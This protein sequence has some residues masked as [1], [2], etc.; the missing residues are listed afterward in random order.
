MKTGVTR[1]GFMGQAA[2][3]AGALSALATAAAPNIAQAGVVQQARLQGKL[4]VVQ[5]LDFHP[6]HNALNK[7]VIEDWAATNIGAQNLDLSDLAGFLGSS[8]IYEK[9]QAQKQAGQPVDFLFHG[10]SARLLQVYDLVT[11]A[12]PLVN[13][14][15][16]KWGRVYSS[17]RAQHVIDNKWIGLPFY[18]R[19]GG[20]W[21]R[22]DKFAE[23]GLSL[24]TGFTER[25]DWIKD[26][27]WAVSKP[28]DN[29]YGW[30][31][32]VNRSGDGQSLVMDMIYAW[33]GAIAD[34]TGQ[35]VTLFSPETIDAIQWLTDIYM[36]PGFQDT[37][38]PPGVNS[39]NDISNNEAWL[40]GTL[41][42]TS[43]A[44]TLYAKS[45]FDQTV[46]PEGRLLADVTTF[47]QRPY[48]PAGIRLQ[49]SGGHYFYFMKGSRNFDV[50]A[51]LA[52]HML[53][54]EV[55]TQLWKISSGY[56]V[57][58]YENR[59]DNPIISENRISRS[60]RPVS[61]NEP[62]FQGVAY[63]GPL[64][65]A[66]DAV[67]SQTVVTDMMGEILAGKSVI[68]AVRDAHLRCVD[69]YQSFGYKGR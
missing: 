40:A 52:E 30:G 66:A 18:D 6:D 43:N 54:D 29:F 19:V 42:F 47:V 57:P 45:V 28:R 61:F 27:C 13:R 48:G 8:N 4:Q 26:A 25:W 20:Y 65:E 11:D 53:Q 37:I 68:A 16:Q 12:T 15:I 14:A 35:I 49:G 22:E 17:A 7:K 10:L 23:A 32:T 63:R 67:D 31:M 55:Q 60:F 3:T 51:Q 64:S 1:R 56:V 24:Q 36:T 33:G 2:A 59:W 58:A 69:I 44:G 41:A 62:P 9:L 21:V 38:T 46:T 39:W 34:P 5:V 50:A